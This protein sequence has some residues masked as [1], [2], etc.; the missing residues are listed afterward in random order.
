MAAVRKKRPKSLKEDFL[1][2]M[3]TELQ[4]QQ[5][6]GTQTLTFREFI[7]HPD[8]C[9]LE[10]SPV[11]WAIV[12]ASEG[13]PV[14]TIDD[15]TCRAIFCG[16]GLDVMGRPRPRP[17]VIGI[18]AGRGGGKTSRLLGPKALHSGWTINCSNAMSAERPRVPITTPLMVNAESAMQYIKGIV[19]QSTIL[20]GARIS[21]PNAEEFIII[22]RPDGIEVEIMMLAPQPKGANL[23]GPQPLSAMID[24]ACFFFTMGY[25]VNDQDQYD[26]AMPRLNLI[27]DAQF[28]M[29]STPWV[30]GEGLL[31]QKLQEFRDNP[32]GEVL[33]VCEVS[34]YM[35]RGEEDDGHLHVGLTEE[36][37]QRE[38]MAKAMPAGSSSLLS[39]E[40][41]D[42]AA[43]IKAVGE[44]YAIAA[45]VDWGFVRDCTAEVHGGK[46]RNSV[47]HTMPD[48]SDV[49]EP[50]LYVA[51]GMSILR[52]N[53]N[54]PLIPSYVAAEICAAVKR[55]HCIELWSDPYEKTSM[56]EH[57]M[58]NGVKL[59]PFQ[60]G[61][62]EKSKQ[63]FCL[64]V[65][66]RFEDRAGPTIILGNL[67]E[68]ERATMVASLKKIA[69]IPQSGHKY[70]IVFPASKMVRGVSTGHA[71]EVSALMA[72]LWGLGLRPGAAKQ[73]AEAPKRPVAQPTPIERQLQAA[74]RR[75]LPN[76]GGSYV[77]FG[78]QIN[79]RRF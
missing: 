73:K 8:F 18:E 20:R 66:D 13:R 16:H 58:R 4:R 63:E 54:E 77:T 68:P 52:P 39:P 41:V 34:T 2:N 22:K 35:L 12:D 49:I 74:Q 76:R 32:D 36:T 9:N 28:W 61:T 60:W 7:S 15:A 50:E 43:K 67:P 37:Y 72:M 78:Q 45:G 3:Q 10:L 40:A 48:G 46:Y 71:D 56:G 59:L 42:R 6:E 30:K 19:N 14:T 69:K 65:R 62:D 31:E 79:K 57:C 51:L 29:F 25:A 5:A 23:R 38:I 53:E 55:A 47:V 1:V 27:D 44:P 11:L 17:K 64:T 75:A 24:E 21:N 33:G 70:K 26:A